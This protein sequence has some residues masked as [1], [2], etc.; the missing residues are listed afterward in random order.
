MGKTFGTDAAKVQSNRN[1][2]AGGKPKMK[3]KKKFSERQKKLLLQNY[4]S[5][6]EEEESNE[7][8][9]KPALSKEQII[10]PRVIP[11]HLVKKRQLEDSK[12]K[13]SKKSREQVESEVSDQEEE[14]EEEA[15]TSKG[16]KVIVA[17]KKKD[18][19]STVNSDF[20]VVAKRTIKGKAKVVPKDDG[21]DGES[22]KDSDEDDDDDELE[23]TFEVHSTIE[24]SGWAD[25]ISKILA[26][27][28]KLESNQNSVVLVKASRDYELVEQ[29]SAK[30][31]TQK[32]KLDWENLCRHKPHPNEKEGE[33]RLS[34]IA[35]RGV[36]QLFNTIRQQ[37][38]E[39][40]RNK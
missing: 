16:P 26:K 40:R 3:K 33:R 8:G 14:E 12:T 35:S 19:K 29:P 23:T 20:R 39:R 15:A 4:H 21:S 22:N 31:K 36:V 2:N 30:Q 13:A 37:K 10:A 5:S 32:Q 27:N 17:K 25:V 7:A 11:A 9:S 6:S 1:S 24:N 18:N 28:P 38:L 34:L